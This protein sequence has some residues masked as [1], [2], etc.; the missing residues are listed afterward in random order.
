MEI[1]RYLHVAPA[2]SS[3]EVLH[4]QLPPLGV[5][6]KL[7]AALLGT[8]KHYHVH[9]TQT[10]PKVR[11]LSMH[12][13]ITDLRGLP[14]S[15]THVLGQQSRHIITELHTCALRH[16]SDRLPGNLGEPALLPVRHVHRNHSN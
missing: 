10:S 6:H 7:R 13:G 14:E 8:A 11:T 1:T 4:R 3:V 16:Q 9:L 15:V 5:S 12:P 2:Q